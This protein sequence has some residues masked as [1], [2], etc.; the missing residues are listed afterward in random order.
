MIPC[1]VPDPLKSLQRLWVALGNGLFGSLMSS[2]RHFPRLHDIGS[3]LHP[4]L[5][6][7]HAYIDHFKGV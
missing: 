3:D 2:T 6:S 1:P 5:F 7:C 4:Y